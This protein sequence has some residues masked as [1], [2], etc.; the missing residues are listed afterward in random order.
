MHPKISESEY[1]PIHYDPKK[2][3]M[4]FTE[5]LL[6]MMKVGAVDQLEDACVHAVLNFKKIGSANTKT[7]LRA[8]LSRHHTE[9][10]IIM[11]GHRPQ[12][13]LW[14]WLDDYDKT[15]AFEDL[16]AAGASKSALN[17]LYRTFDA[18][19]KVE[20]SLRVDELVYQVPPTKPEHLKYMVSLLKTFHDEPFSSNQ[21]TEAMKGDYSMHEIMEAL[22]VAG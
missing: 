3:T 20:M 5:N 1:V 21:Y 9:A 15:M 7:Y 12:S 19:T 22:Q 13:K 10:F 14:Q 16:A 8:R 17:A 11:L 6:A 2:P 18:D 4:D